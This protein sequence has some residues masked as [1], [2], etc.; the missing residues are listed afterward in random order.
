MT[1]APAPS[2][3]A[4]FLAIVQASEELQRG[5]VELFRAHGLTI[6]QYNVLRILRGAGPA[7]VTCGDVAGRLLRYDPDV[8]RLM[9]RLNTR[10]LVERE[11]DSKDRR[12]V[13]TRI[14]PEGKALLRTLDGPVTAMHA[15]QLGHISDTRLA[16]LAALLEEARAAVA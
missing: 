11:R 9:D 13:R 14:T 15:R 16:R 7:G 12:V 4:V 6:A 2:P 10:G 8:T 5:F 3:E 1:P